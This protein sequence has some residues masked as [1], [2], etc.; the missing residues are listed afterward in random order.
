MIQNLGEIDCCCSIC[1]G[2][3]RDPA[4]IECGHTFC[5]ECIDLSL[6]KKRQCPTCRKNL[7]KGPLPVLCLR[8]YIN[9]LKIKC[10]NDCGW[11]DNIE[12]YDTHLR[13]C[14]KSSNVDCPK[15][16]KTILRTSLP[17]HLLMD[18]PYRQIECK[19]CTMKV[20]YHILRLH[21]RVECELRIVSCDKCQENMP[22]R[23]FASHK[24]ERCPHRLV[25]CQNCRQPFPFVEL[26]RHLSM[27]SQRIVKCGECSEAM[28]FDKLQ[29]H[30]E[31][32]IGDLKTYK[33]FVCSMDCLYCFKS[34]QFTG[35]EQ[36]KDHL[37][38]CEKLKG[39]CNRC[40]QV[41]YR[42]ELKQHEK[43]CTYQTMIC[44][45][46]CKRY[47]REEMHRH[48]D[49]CSKNPAFGYVPHRVL[50]ARIV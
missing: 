7:Q 49:K 26:E 25:P 15:C 39:H 29:S 21:N 34:I 14:E 3:F 32:C 46:C 38:I 28:P 45:F 41:F 35:Y 9:C 33:Y 36:I 8:T 50:Q 31:A 12:K 18:C 10:E 13:C 48:W 37:A 6:E 5:R 16:R 43:C 30:K 19:L 17:K 40:H 24:T 27:C 2:I 22:Y 47:K 1:L 11:T 4:T 23:L 20:E 44:H 42:N